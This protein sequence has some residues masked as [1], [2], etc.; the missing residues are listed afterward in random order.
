MKTKLILTSIV[1]AAFLVATP[2][3]WALPPPQHSAFGVIASIDHKTHT[4]TLAPPKGAEPLVF[5]WKNST[6]FKQRGS[7]ICTGALEPGLPVRVSYRREVGRLVP[8]EVSLRTDATT[9]CTTGDCC[10][11]RS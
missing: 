5:V 9:R 8:S 3:G 11:K 6:R 1:A 2:S 10:T 7:R 4:L